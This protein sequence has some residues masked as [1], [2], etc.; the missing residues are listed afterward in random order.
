MLDE[1]SLPEAARA[2]QLQPGRV[3]VLLHRAR[4]AL[5]ACLVG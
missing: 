1:V 2:L 3:A 5:E 4:K